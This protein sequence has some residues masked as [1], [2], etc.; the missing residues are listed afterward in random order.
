LSFAGVNL[1]IIGWRYGRPF[2]QMLAGK[3]G[4]VYWLEA[5]ILFAGGRMRTLQPLELWSQRSVGWHA[6]SG[7]KQMQRKSDVFLDSATKF[8]EMK[9]TVNCCMKQITIKLTWVAKC[10]IILQLE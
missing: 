4:G 8:Y 5:T 9:S 10:G 7:Y 2:M 6:I 3:K 1:L